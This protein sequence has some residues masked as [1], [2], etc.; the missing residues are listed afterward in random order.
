M[1]GGEA[2]NGDYSVYRCFVDIIGNKDLGGKTILYLIDGLWGSTNWGHPPVPWQM[3]PFN[4]D[5]PN[6]LF[7]SQDPVAIESVG[8]DFLYYE[9]DENNPYEGGPTTDN[10]GP[11]PHY[12]G[13]D[14]FMH[15]AADSLNW[16]GG[17]VYDPEHDGVPL[18]RSLG[19]H[20]HWNNA[21]DKQYSRNL[22]RN[23]GIELVSNVTTAVEGNRPASV[24][25]FS[26]D[27]NYPN[28]FNPTTTIAYHLGA[29]SDVTLTLF[30]AKGETVRTLVRGFHTAGTHEVVWDGLMENGF[31]APSGVYYCH[32]TARNEHQAFNQSNRM[33]LCK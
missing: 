6:S 18:P 31:P 33:L 7:L 1:Y 29:S 28:P 15:Q 32:M 11:F 24:E 16:P 23:Q 22:G 4:K 21:I 2:D 27:R 17:L 5:W 13:V 26:L 8:F 30:N 19:T 12:P 14:D 25:G 3:P 20:E 10:N 9:F